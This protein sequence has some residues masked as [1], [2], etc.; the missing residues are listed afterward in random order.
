MY[1]YLVIRKHNDMDFFTCI[2]YMNNLVYFAHPEMD[3]SGWNC[4][5][6]NLR[7]T[8]KKVVESPVRGEMMSEKVNLTRFQIKN[9][10]SMLVVR[11][12]WLVSGLAE[13]WK[14]VVWIY[15]KFKFMK[16]QIEKSTKFINSFLKKSKFLPHF[17][18]EP[19]HTRQYLF[20]PVISFNNYWHNKGISY[21]ILSII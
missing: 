1:K 12:G 9:W 18:F 4:L 10:Y 15:R 14:N 7:N 6:H 21:I 16:F 8:T 3:F 17:F 5:V 20:L 19:D 13:I 11:V 2:L